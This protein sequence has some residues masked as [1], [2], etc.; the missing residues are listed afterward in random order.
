M[1]TIDRQEAQDMLDAVLLQRNVA[2]NDII[3]LSA[4]LAKVNRE[5]AQLKEQLDK[6][7]TDA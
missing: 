7:N 4:A 2:Q 5:L 3:R 6:V 1:D